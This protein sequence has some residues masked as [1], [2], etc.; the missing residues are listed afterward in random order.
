MNG[1]SFDCGDFCIALQK[2]H[3]N[4]GQI[5]ALF[6][7]H[8]DARVVGLVVQRIVGNLFNIEVNGGRCRSFGVGGHL[9]FLVG[10]L[11]KLRF[12]QGWKY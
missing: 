9:E 8:L 11:L 4:R 5:L 3:L 2:G 12:Q 1:P 10:R 7:E 6:R